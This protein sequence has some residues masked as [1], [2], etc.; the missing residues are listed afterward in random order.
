[1]PVDKQM[2]MD[3]FNGWEPIAVE[4]QD[5]KGFDEPI[6]GKYECEIKDL[7]YKTIVGKSDGKEYEVITMKMKCVKDLEG[8]VSL[9]RNIDR[10]YFLGAS[11]YNDDPLAGY[12]RLLTDLK[13]ADLYDPAVVGLFDI[14]DAV[15]FLKDKIVGKI[16]KVTAF[17]QKGKQQIRIYKP[18]DGGDAPPVIKGVF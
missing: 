10:S 1:M 17:P 13:S 8:D 3:M 2:V 9:N 5:V 14:T 12:K 16:I 4:E 11:D 18:K 15:A 7:S 6:K